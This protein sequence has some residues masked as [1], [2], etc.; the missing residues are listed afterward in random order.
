MKSDRQLCNPQH[1]MPKEGTGRWEHENAHETNY[2]GDYCA[3]YKC[4]DC[5]HVWREELPQ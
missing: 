2:N 1:P 5:G 4:D 3:E